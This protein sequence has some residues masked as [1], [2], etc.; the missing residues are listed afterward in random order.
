MILKLNHRKL[1]SKCYNT[2]FLKYTNACVYAHVCADMSTHTYMSKCVYAHVLFSYFY[3]LEF[4]RLHNPTKLFY[5][6]LQDKISKF[7]RYSKCFIKYCVLSWPLFSFPIV[8]LGLIL[9]SYLPIILNIC[10]CPNIML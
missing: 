1:I 3:Y 5:K 6:N 2:F 8:S 10:L 4:I 7:N 9:A